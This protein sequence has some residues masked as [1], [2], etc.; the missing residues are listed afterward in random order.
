MVGEVMAKARKCKPDAQLRQRLALLRQRGLTPL[1]DGGPTVAEL[2]DVVGDLTL[3]ELY[4]M[5][6]I[7][8]DDQL[9]R[10]VEDEEPPP[11]LTIVG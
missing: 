5:G 9:R 2:L 7:A 1:Q 8:N 11:P 4:R 3:Y 6:R 10:F